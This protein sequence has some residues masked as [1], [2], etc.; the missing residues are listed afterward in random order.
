MLTQN[1]SKSLTFIQMTMNLISYFSSLSKIW[2][3]ISVRA[4]VTV[5][6]YSLRGK[7][8]HNLLLAHGVKCKYISVNQMNQKQYSFFARNPHNWTWLSIVHKWA[9]WW[10][11]KGSSEINAF[12][13]TNPPTDVQPHDVCDDFGFCIFILQID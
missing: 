13:K 10:L 12:I 6:I 11:I 4:H 8:S 7:P 9:R 2:A 1:L 3:E 5:F